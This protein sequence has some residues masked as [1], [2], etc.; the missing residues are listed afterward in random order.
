[1]RKALVTG[2]LGFI[3][4]YLC[5]ALS[6]SGEYEVFGLDWKRGPHEDIRTCRFPVADICFHLAAQTKVS[7]RDVAEDA[8]I[9]IM[10]TLR[11]LERYREQVV[12]AASYAAPTPVVPYAISKNVCEHYCRFYG[13][14]M[15][16]FCNITGPGGP[17]VIEKF[18]AADTL[19]IT[20]TGQQLREYAPVSRAIEAL[21]N[22]A[23]APPGSLHV[24][25][26]TKLSV[27]DI[28]DL[29]YAAKPRE[30]IEQD[31]FD[32]KI[33]CQN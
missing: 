4:T 11:I 1:M 22:A 14:R 30:F 16:R 24:L 17:G 8:D 26:G 33:I 27:L 20:G 13:A 19:K 6:A 21:I 32:A 29:C 31:E 3:G 18:A 2:D 9:N 7:C 15:V 12:F 23:D 28:A 25:Q 5:R 10:G